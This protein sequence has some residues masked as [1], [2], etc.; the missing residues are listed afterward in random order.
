MEHIIETENVYKNP[1]PAARD[2]VKQIDERYIVVQRN[3][4]PIV[5]KVDSPQYIRRFTAQV[6][7]VTDQ[8]SDPE[9]HVTRAKEHLAMASYLVEQKD[10]KKKQ[11]DEDRKKVWAELYPDG[12]PNAYQWDSLFMST[13]RAI[14]KILSLQSA[15]RGPNF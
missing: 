2:S 8:N 14:T 15:L 1:A 9:F 3:A 6:G 4:L 12:D 13:Q 10:V 5:E 11:L 7:G